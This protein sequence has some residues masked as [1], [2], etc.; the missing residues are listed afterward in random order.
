MTPIAPSNSMLVNVL[1]IASRV[2][3]LAVCAASAAVRDS[4]AQ[5]LAL[6][7][8]EIAVE[9]P[10]TVANKPTTLAKLPQLFCKNPYHCFMIPQSAITVTTS[11]LSTLDSA[12]QLSVPCRRSHRMTQLPDIEI[13]TPMIETYRKLP[14]PSMMPRRSLVR[15][16][17]LPPRHQ[18]RPTTPQTRSPSL[19]I[20][21]P[22]G[23]L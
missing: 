7:A 20:F 15:R 17:R 8:T 5:A 11:E 23:S 2:S 13:S 21:A 10:T 22:H 6:L 18:T 3:K 12:R 9:R 4:S 14:E 1:L 19:S 16:D